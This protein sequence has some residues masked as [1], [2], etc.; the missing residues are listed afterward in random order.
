[1]FDATIAS[2]T[3]VHGIYHANRRQ[4]WWVFAPVGGAV[5]YNM[6]VYDV[7]HDA[8]SRYSVPLGYVPTASC[9]YYDSTSAV[10]VPYL[11]GMDNSG[12]VPR[13]RVYDDVFSAPFPATDGGTAYRGYLTTRAYVPAGLGTNV[14]LKAPI[15]LGTVIAGG[16]T[17]RVK[18]IRDFSAETVTGD[19]QIALTGSVT[20][21]LAVAQGCELNAVGVVQWEIGDATA[22]TNS[23]LWILDGFSAPWEEREVRQS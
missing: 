21:V 3:S 6:L 15:L 2:D 10:M 16:V 18:A 17:I 20:R 7:K 4:I 5:T 19:A 1:L 11:G 13:I 22:A 8:Y 23:F 12:G 9:V 14:E